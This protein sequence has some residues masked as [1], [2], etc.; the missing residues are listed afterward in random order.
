MGKTRFQKIIEFIF[1]GNYFYGICVVGIVLETSIQLNLNINEP[2]L[3]LMAFLSTVLFYNHPYA[4][5]YKSNQ[6][7]PRVLWYTKNQNFVIFNQLLFTIALSSAFVYI[8][9]NHN[10]QIINTKTIDWILLLLFPFIGVL[11]YG[12]NAISKQINLRKIG[13]L[14]PFIIGFV[15]A[16][17]SNVYPIL[18]SNIILK[19]CYQWDVLSLVLFLKSFLF[20]SM[21]AILFDIKDYVVDSKE[22][23][24]TLMVKLGLKKTI[25]YVIVPLSMLGILSYIPYALLLNFSTF[26]LLL[27]MI[28]FVCLLLATRLFRK[29]RKLLYYL[30]VID[31]LLLVKAIFGIVA[32]SL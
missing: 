27:M 13:L 2:M 15:W 14:K 21:L 22:E 29:R 18:Y 16:G 31:G 12:I 9:I 32:S 3:F 28:P 10:Q 17:M 5:N 1:Y 26:K 8:S 25:F 6:S 4:R 24:N 19:Q 30:I 11:Y 20:I 7:N 23:L